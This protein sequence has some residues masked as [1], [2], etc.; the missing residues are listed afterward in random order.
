ML[1]KDWF[2]LLHVSSSVQKKK[3][4]HVIFIF[5][6]I[7]L[8]DFRRGIVLSWFLPTTRSRV[9][10]VWFRFVYSGMFFFSILKIFKLFLPGLKIHLKFSVTTSTTVKK[11]F[12]TAQLARLSLFLSEELAVSA[13]FGCLARLYHKP[14]KMLRFKRPFRTGLWTCLK[15]RISNNNTMKFK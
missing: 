11:R 1:N 12:L 6:F 14:R 9:F 5:I 15:V 2:F 10:I 13:R 3:K 4:K 7:I 8:S